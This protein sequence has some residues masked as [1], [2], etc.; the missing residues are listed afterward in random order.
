MLCPAKRA[1]SPP[2]MASSYKSKAQLKA[3]L[4]QAFAEAGFAVESK[5]V[6][7][8]DQPDFVFAR[9]GQRFVV[10]LESA[11]MNRSDVIHGLMAAALLRARR[12]AIATSDA[13]VLPV[14][15]VSTLND[16]VVDAVGTF[17]T[18]EAPH[19]AWG[20]IE[21]EGGLHLHGVDSV[22]PLRIGRRRAPARVPSSHELDPFTDLGQWLAKV[23][24]APRLSQRLLSA[25]RTP[26]D[27]ARHLALAARV[28]E[29]TAAR[30]VR[31]LRG[32]QFI[33]ERR[34]TLRI[35]RTQEFFSRWRN[36]VNAVPRRE[37]SARFFLPTGA[38]D[39]QLHQALARQAWRRV[40]DP[41]PDQSSINNVMIEWGKTPRACLG[42]FEASAALGSG[43][44]M[45]A[46]IHFYLESITDDSLQHFGLERSEPDRAHVR[47]I[48]PT[49]PESLFRAA[50]IAQTRHG[51]DVP[52]CDIVQA[53][54]DVAEHPARGREQA[55]AIEREVLAKSVFPPIEDVA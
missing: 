1:R 34:G 48:E 55:D 50:V 25:P 18:R 9:K 42:L 29:P 4:E 26:I 28:S 24:I 8:S 16:R 17:M 37:I 45:G 22:A 54:L 19:D 36:A 33:D 12:H 23:M 39:E 46:P 2:H 30:W 14:V 5:R 10:D 52:S 21:R 53:W 3:Q 41:A 27:R 32:E 40:G 31:L 44:V 49:Y 15:G 35:V 11:G 6:D 7:A 13:I 47:V 43:H 38:P 20:L 51:L